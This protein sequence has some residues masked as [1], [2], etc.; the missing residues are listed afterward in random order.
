MSDEQV[1]NL[2]ANLPSAGEVR[3]PREGE[4]VDA[5]VQ[6]V[7]LTGPFSNGD[8]GIQVTFVGLVDTEG[9]EFSHKAKYTIPTS[10][11]QDFIRRIFL[12]ATHDLCIVPRNSK[13]GIVADDDASRAAVLAA[14]QTIVGAKFPLKLSADRQGYMRERYLRQKAA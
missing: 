7:E 2:L 10:N 8:Y 9:R 11:S 6:D 1:E 12:G 3:D 13:S 5:R 4:H 14:F